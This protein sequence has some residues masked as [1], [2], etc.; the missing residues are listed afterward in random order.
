MTD[1][2]MEVW[3]WEEIYSTSY[4]VILLWKDIYST[5]HKVR[6]RERNWFSY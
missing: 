6:L 3:E 2:K 5:S 4:Q 1:L